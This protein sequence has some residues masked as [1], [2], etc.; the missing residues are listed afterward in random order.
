MQAIRDTGW[1]LKT[2][3]VIATPSASF[4]ADKGITK[5]LRL[6]QR[7]NDLEE[8]RKRKKDMGDSLLR[9]TSLKWIAQYIGRDFYLTTKGVLSLETICDIGDIMIFSTEQEAADAILKSGDRS[10]SPN[11]LID[12]KEFVY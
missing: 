5:N 3:F 10:L 6:A 9:I 1:S 11:C 7:F 8:A 4:I 12:P 2:M